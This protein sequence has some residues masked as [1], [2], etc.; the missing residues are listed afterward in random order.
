MFD[1]V[2]EATAPELVIEV[3]SP[4]TRATD[5]ETKRRLYYRLGVRYYAIVDQI[6]LRD[7]V[8]SLR[9]LGYQ[10]GRRGY[11]RMRLNRRGRLWLESV[12]AWLGIGDG[13]VVCYDAAGVAIEGFTEQVQQRLQ[14]EVALD[15]AEAARDEAEAARDEAEAARAETEEQSRREA[16]ARRAAEEKVKRLEAE[17]RRLRGDE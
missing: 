17:L 3:T 4:A 16:A 10:R 9:L 15:E 2:E 6:S 5:L 14:T 8:R 7:G 11:V 13:R 12:G 1:V